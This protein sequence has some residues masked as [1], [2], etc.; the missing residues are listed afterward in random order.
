MIVK[1]GKQVCEIK[2]IIKISLLFL[3]SGFREE[4]SCIDF[5]GAICFATILFFRAR[6][7]HELLVIGIVHFRGTFFFIGIRCFSIGL[8]RLLYM[9]FIVVFYVVEEHM[10]VN[11]TEDVRVVG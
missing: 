2:E 8:D 3:V 11:T 1:S 10:I 9:V 6:V 4:V 7:C 5:L